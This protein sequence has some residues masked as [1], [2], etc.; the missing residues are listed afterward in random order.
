M[1][2][3][4]FKQYRNI[5][6]FIFGALLAVSEL[7]ATLASNKWFAAQPIVIS[8]TLTF[9]CIV[10]MR[11][12]WFALIPACLGGAVFCIASGAGIEQYLI[13]CVGN[14]AALASMVYFRIWG[15][16]GVRSSRIRLF[17]FVATA[18]VSMQAARW[19]LSLPFGGRLDTLLVYLGTD[20][21]S[22]LFAAVVVILMKNT[23]GMIE[24][25]KA[26][27]FRIQFEAEAK[28]TKDAYGYDENE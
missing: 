18:Y 7:I 4:T 21:I 9:I 26:Y 17:I 11:W 14:C 5:D 6:L 27:L 12:S 1:N 8:T 23:D 16:D 19:L 15:K 20:I 22:L 25:Q 13:Y 28:V 3:I 24:D 10:M 2:K